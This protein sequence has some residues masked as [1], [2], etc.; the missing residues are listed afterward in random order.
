MFRGT[1]T[2]SIIHFSPQRPDRL[3][4]RLSPL[5]N[6]YRGLFPHGREA[7]HSPP[8]NAEVRGGAAIPPLYP[9]AVVTVFAVETPCFQRYS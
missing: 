1:V 5:C 6:G 2:M 7:D 4:G 3:W 8:C 9:F